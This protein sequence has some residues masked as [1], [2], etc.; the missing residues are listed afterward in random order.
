MAAGPIYGSCLRD[1]RKELLAVGTVPFTLEPKRIG[2]YE[3][4]HD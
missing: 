2:A 3:V 1:C 4:S